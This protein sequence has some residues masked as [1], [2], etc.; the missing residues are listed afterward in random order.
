MAKPHPFFMLLCLHFVA[1]GALASPGFGPALTQAYQASLK[2]KVN[3]SRALLRQLPRQETAEQAAI[4]LVENYND[5]LELCVEQDGQQKNRLIEAQEQR[6]EKIK[7]LAGN[8]PWKDYALAEVSMQL[9]MGKLLFGNRLSAA[10]SFRSAY[11]Q[12][13]RNAKH[14]PHFIPNKKNLGVLQVMIGSVPDQY[15]GFLNIIGLKG[16][17]REGLANLTTAA[18]APNPFQAEARLLQAVVL[19]ALAQDEANPAVAQVLTLVKA[20]PDNLIFVFTALHLLKK[21]NQG[22]AAIKLYNSR[23]VG[24]AFLSFP[25]LH[26]MAADLY[27]Y[28]GDY[29]NSIKENNLFLQQHKGQHYLKSANYKLYIAYL[30]SDHPRQAKWH[31]NRIKKVGIAETEEDKYAASYANRNEQQVVPLLKARLHADGGYYQ[32]ALQDLEQLQLSAALP[33]AVRAEYLYRKARVYHGLNEW[34]EA[35]TCYRKTIALAASTDLYFAPN[36]A[37]QLGYIY[38]QWHQPEQAKAYFRLAMSYRGHAYK[39]SI[40]SKA[41]LALSTF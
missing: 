1:V 25:Y 26:H 11:L 34:Q 12:Y 8:N 10:W 41:K 22:E 27:L 14:W 28:Q 2:L 32:E 13:T 3:S 31:F 23:P 17:V 16:S 40:D 39:N 6:L 35:A 15:I 19:H 20:Q 7:R 38:Q 24:S 29:E 21:N 9:A 36:A 30:L 5:F 4:L 33:V 18:T 37:L